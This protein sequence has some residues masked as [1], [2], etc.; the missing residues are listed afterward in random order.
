M[1]WQTIDPVKLSFLKSG[2]SLSNNNFN[3]P[4]NSLTIPPS[5]ILPQ[6]FLLGTSVSSPVITI[7]PRKSSTESPLLRSY[8]STSGNQL[9]DETGNKIRITGVNWYGF[10][11]INYVLDGL[12]FRSY[13]SIVDQMIDLGFN[14]FRIPI[15]N[16]MILNKNSNFSTINY[17]LNP[18]LLYQTPI[19]ILDKFV[20][21]CSCVGMRIIL[22]RHS[23][24]ASNYQLENYWYLPGDSYYTEE[25]ITAD[26]VMLA[27]RYK[28]F[29]TIIGIDLWN[30]PKTYSSWNNWS[31]AATRIGNAILKVNPKILIIVE[32]VGKNTW[33]GGNL[34][35]VERFPVILSYPNKLLYSIHEYGSC[36]YPQEW[37]SDPS[38]PSNLKDVWNSNWGYLLKNSSSPKAILVGEFGCPL[39]NLV[40]KS[41]ISSFL[42]YMNGDYDLNGKNNLPY[43]NKGLSWI[44][45]NVSPGGETGGILNNDWET[46]D[47]NKINTLLSSMSSK[48]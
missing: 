13:K 46:V 31:P 17:Y 28:D 40:D 44:Y 32:G 38:F 16:Q 39:V 23:C 30:E 11:T 20:N 24:L 3:S 9:I 36:V 33:W 1:D 45:W 37:F 41:W 34:M 8:I 42:S 5:S 7:V 21:Y 35:G 15:S 18:D 12:Q 4:S 26:L 10:D 48:F 6:S 29:P 47:Q 27:I 19:Q 43:G 14:L 2:F 22:D 25:Q